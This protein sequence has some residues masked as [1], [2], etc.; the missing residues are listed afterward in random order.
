MRDDFSPCCLLALPL[1]AGNK[2]NPGM[3]YRSLSLRDKR[4]HINK[5]VHKI[6][7]EAGNLHLKSTRSTYDRL[8][9]T[10]NS[11][12]LPYEANSKHYE[13]LKILQMAFFRNVF[14]KRTEKEAVFWSLGLIY[15]SQ[16][17]ELDRVTIEIKH[18][19]NF[20]RE[21]LCVVTHTV[22]FLCKHFLLFR[23]P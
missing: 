23:L 5:T 11:L 16:R 20:T 22:W 18:S 14:Q 17:C 4:I 21:P 8:R 2:V 19:N 9:I 15:L 3:N 1:L 7:W 6:F 13:I 10:I 12:K